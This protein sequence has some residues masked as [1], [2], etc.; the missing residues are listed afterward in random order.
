M[1]TKNLTQ[2]IN[3]CEKISE[4]S[5]KF[6]SSYEMYYR[7]KSAGL[8]RAG[9]YLHVA[10]K[11]FEKIADAI[12]WSHAKPLVNTND[13]PVNEKKIMMSMHERALYLLRSSLDLRESA[14]EIPKMQQLKDIK[15]PEK[16]ETIYNLLV[17]ALNSLMRASFFIDEALYFVETAT[18][19]TA[20]LAAGGIVNTKDL[21]TKKDI[22][23]ITE[24]M[25]IAANRTKHIK[26]E[27]HE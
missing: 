5:V 4:L 22:N 13:F 7:V 14:L 23:Q 18:I 2:L 24:R 8:V 9:G 19:K 27:D 3:E 11:I 12:G 21:V 26:D 20:A 17:E 6:N 15:D 25:K 10:S 16:Y 1:K